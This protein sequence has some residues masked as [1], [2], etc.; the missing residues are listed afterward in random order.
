MAYVS[1]HSYGASVPSLHMQSLQAQ[2]PPAWRAK[3]ARRAALN[4]VALV[5]LDLVHPGN[6]GPLPP[7]PQVLVN[8]AYAL[9]LLKPHDRAMDI[10]LG[11]E[12]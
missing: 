8:K 3:Q 12:Y 2:N 10:V 7:S 1:G 5:V 6:L 11:H 9:G 4:E